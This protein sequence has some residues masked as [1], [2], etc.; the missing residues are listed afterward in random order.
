MIS[1]HVYSVYFVNIAPQWTIFRCWNVFQ[2]TGINLDDLVFFPTWAAYKNNKPKSN[3]S[4][5]KWL[6]WWIFRRIIGWFLEHWSQFW[7]FLTPNLAYFA[8]WSNLLTQK[9]R[10]MC[11]YILKSILSTHTH[12]GGPRPVL[13]KLLTGFART[14]PQISQFLPKIQC[15]GLID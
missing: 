5:H 2:H 6:L 7:R 13:S 3:I 4:T 12:F 14:S 15:L 9:V 8:L 1:K 10:L 11:F